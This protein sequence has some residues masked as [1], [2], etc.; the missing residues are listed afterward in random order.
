M[1]GEHWTKPEAIRE[2]QALALKTQPTMLRRCLACDEWMR[3][4]GRD[5][6]ICNVCKRR[7]LGSNHA[8]PGPVGD[9]VVFCKGSRRAA[10]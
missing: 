6:R 7:H 2:K 10:W 1:G 3:S 8:E 5:H 4:A 9:R